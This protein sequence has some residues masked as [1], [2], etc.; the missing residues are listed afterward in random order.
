MWTRE[1][2]VQLAAKGSEGERESER[3]RFFMNI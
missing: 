1:T 3:P 2:V